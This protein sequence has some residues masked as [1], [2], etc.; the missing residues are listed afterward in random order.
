M[1]LCISA[2]EGCAVAVCDYC[3]HCIML[4]LQ[5]LR[6][7][8]LNVSKKNVKMLCKQVDV[9]GDGNSVEFT[10]FIGLYRKLSKRQDI[11]DLFSKYAADEYMTKEEFDTFL[12]EFQ[13]LMAHSS[14]LVVMFWYL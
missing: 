12:L 10:E 9:N 7:L 11:L 3:I 6:S 14:T 2:A 8:N 13:V 5:A 1:D 4:C